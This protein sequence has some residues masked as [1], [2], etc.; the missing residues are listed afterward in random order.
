[1]IC[2]LGFC[3]VSGVFSYTFLRFVVIE[4]VGQKYELLNQFLTPWMITY[5]IVSL[6]FGFFLFMIGKQ[7]SHRTAGPVYAFE[8]F[9]ND[10]IEGKDRK[11]KLRK[12]D[13]F[14]HLEE[15]AEQI[16]I[17]LQA[18]NATDLIPLLPK[19]ITMEDPAVEEPPQQ[20]VS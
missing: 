4:L 11:L 8:R 13:E 10:F 9:V 19:G 14:L 17:A 3:L 2:G 12:G 1:M 5:S 20:N 7:L 18:K 15:L 6:C 16:S